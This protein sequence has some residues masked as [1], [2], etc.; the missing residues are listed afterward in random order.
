MELQQPEPADRHGEKTKDVVRPLCRHRNQSVLSWLV[1]LR[2]PNT[3]SFQAEA[4]TREEAR[5]VTLGERIVRRS[6]MLQQL[7]GDKLHVLILFFLYILQGI[8]LGLKDSIPLILSKKVPATNN[9]G[10]K[11]SL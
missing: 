2:D 1:Q 6:S 5:K 9:N 11:T 8:P 3:Y 7:E 10:L 4:E